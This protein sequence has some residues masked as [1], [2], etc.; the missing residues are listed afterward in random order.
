MVMKMYSEDND[1]DVVVI[2][3]HNY[4]KAQQTLMFNSWRKKNNKSKLRERDKDFFVH[5]QYIYSIHLHEQFSWNTVPYLDASVLWKRK[6]KERDL[7]LPSWEDELLIIA[8]HSLFENMVLVPEELIYGRK[9]LQQDI[10]W[11]YIRTH[12]RL[13]HWSTGVEI[14]LRKLKKNESRLSILELALVRM[15]KLGKD[16]SRGKLIL[17]FHELLAYLIIDWLWCYPK[18]HK[19]PY[20]TP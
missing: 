1:V 19:K 9:I 7:F 5:P 3:P 15:E 4:E 13:L 11:S 12:A 10:D 14:I 6:R 20:G 18:R 17:L 2:D 8:A 16:I